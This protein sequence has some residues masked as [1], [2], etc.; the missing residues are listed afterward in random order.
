MKKHS[1]LKWRS[2]AVLDTSEGVPQDGLAALVVKE[3]CDAV[4]ATKEGDGEVFP[5]KEVLWQRDR[6][7]VGRIQH[8]SKDRRSAVFYVKE[9]EQWRLPMVFPEA[10][11]EL[12]IGDDATRKLADEGGSGDR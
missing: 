9:A 1:R 8:R 12:W 3:E 11:E 7:V 2:H 5:K 6:D 4:A 10:F